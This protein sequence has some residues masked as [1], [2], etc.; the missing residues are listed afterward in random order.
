MKYTN[1]VLGKYQGSALILFL[2]TELMYVLTSEV[3]QEAI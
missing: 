1:E 2:I 3:W